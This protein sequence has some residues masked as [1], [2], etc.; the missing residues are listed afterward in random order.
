MRSRTDA[1]SGVRESP[2]APPQVAPGMAPAV[3]LSL[4]RTAGN[5]A[6]A[7]ALAGR[8]RTLARLQ[9]AAAFR[10]AATV[11]GGVFDASLRLVADRL[12]VC[13][14]NEQMLA[15]LRTSLV[16]AERQQYSDKRLSD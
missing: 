11:A 5:Q 14:G 13:N 1:P 16:Q 15:P 9:T 6:V 10:A 8:R 4:Q 3:I 2:V 12:D 7:R